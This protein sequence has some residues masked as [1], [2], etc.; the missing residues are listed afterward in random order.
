[1]NTVLSNRQRKQAL[2]QFPKQARQ[3]HMLTPQ[4]VAALPPDVDY[5]KI[6]ASRPAG[7]TIPT[8]IID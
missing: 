7:L 3:E 4:D 5:I 6:K 8:R 2:K 1:M